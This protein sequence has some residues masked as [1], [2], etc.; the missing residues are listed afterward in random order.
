[1]KKSYSRRHDMPCVKVGRKRP[2]I[3]ELVAFAEKIG[4]ATGPVARNHRSRIKTRLYC[5]IFPWG[6]RA[7]LATRDLI[8]FGLEPGSFRDFFERGDK[9]R[10]LD[11]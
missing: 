10:W 9:A 2:R 4:A 3:D 8:V 5:V 11:L 7:I 6:K 1:M